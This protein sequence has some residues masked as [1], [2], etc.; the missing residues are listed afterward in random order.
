MFF[1]YIEFQSEHKQIKRNQIKIALK[2][3]Q[4]K[5]LFL[6]LFNSFAIFF[7]LCVRVSKSGAFK[8]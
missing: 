5:V 6:F 1:F 7:T 8:K 4:L 3:E 2:V